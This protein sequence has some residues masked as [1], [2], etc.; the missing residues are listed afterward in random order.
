MSRS[1]RPFNARLFTW[2]ALAGVAGC[3][4]A[5]ALPWRKTDTDAGSLTENAFEWSPRFGWAAACALAAAAGLLLTALSP[6]SGPGAR[7]WLRFLGT[8]TVAALVIAELGLARGWGE[9]DRVRPAWGLAAAIGIG[10]C[11]V[12]AGGVLLR[13]AHGRPRR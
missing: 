11:S 7:E 12:V 4:A 6:R 13:G 3:L 10:L 1:V 8:G 9:A 2:I 5:L